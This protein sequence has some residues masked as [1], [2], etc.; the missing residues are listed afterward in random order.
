[1]IVTMCDVIYTD[2][3][4]VHGEPALVPGPEQQQPPLQTHQSRLPDDLVKT[5]RVQLTPHLHT[6]G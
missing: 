6:V 4:G 1:M 2:H 3:A 5:L